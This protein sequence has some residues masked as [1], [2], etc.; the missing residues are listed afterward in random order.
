MGDGLDYDAAPAGRASI[1][2]LGAATLPRGEIAQ[3]GI[4]V[5][6]RSATICSSSPT[7]Y[8][9]PGHQTRR[10]TSFPGPATASPFSSATV[11]PGPDRRIFRKEG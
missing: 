7:I 6:N 5:F 1:R 9:G 11:A 4:P 2:I 10:A 3:P 8:S